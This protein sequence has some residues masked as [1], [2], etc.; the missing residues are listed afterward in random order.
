MKCL[1]GYDNANSANVANSIKKTLKIINEFPDAH[2]A[3]FI[4]SIAQIFLKK[5][6]A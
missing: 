4:V 5:F 3:S 6:K 1:K 2:Y